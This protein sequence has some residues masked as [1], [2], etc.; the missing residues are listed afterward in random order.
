MSCRP[1]RASAAA[2]GLAA[3]LLAGCAAPPNQEIG[4]AQNALKAARAAGAE[5]Y[6]PESYAAAADA[7]R[8][9]NEAVMAGD[10]RLALNRAIESR[11]HAQTAIRTAEV[12]QAEAR[13]EAQRQFED[14]QAQVA[15]LA[16]DTEAAGSTR[17]VRRALNDVRE[18]L[19]LAGKALQEAG[20]A[21]DRDDI[22]AAQA[23]MA[24]VR[25]RLDA[26][27]A[28]LAATQVQS[29]KRRNR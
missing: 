18:T 3:L 5:R 7:Y 29:S 19:T 9:A 14:L 24:D 2:C 8:V 28:D 25:V 4:D 12:A 11:D 1:L 17:A 10:Y 6:A 16:A 13:R 22:D 15:Q 26:A 21:L 20:A 27:A 23:T